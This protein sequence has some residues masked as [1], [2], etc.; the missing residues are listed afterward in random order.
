MSNSNSNSNS[1]LGDY[2]SDIE[3]NE[4]NRRYAKVNR[5]VLDKDSDEYRRRR[6][7][8][9]LAVKKSRNKSKLKTQQTLERV[10][11]LK[12]ENDELQQKIEILSKELRLLKDLFMA[13][14][15]NA[16]GTELTEVD[17]KYLTSPETLQ[18]VP[19]K[20]KLDHE[21]Q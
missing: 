9:N 13:H 4:T 17:L 16:H 10:K 7:R 6:E 14:A 19:T 3:F 1:S 12:D 8:N 5:I 18:E 15:S 11:Q 21:Y 20:L 2:A